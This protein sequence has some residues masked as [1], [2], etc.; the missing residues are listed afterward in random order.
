M[1]RV[2][3]KKWRAEKNT[4]NNDKERRKKE[5]E[6]ILAFCLDFNSREKIFCKE[7]RFA[8]FTSI[9]VDRLGRRF[10]LFFRLK[11]LELGFAKLMSDHVVLQCEGSYTNA[12]I[13][14]TFAGKFFKWKFA[15]NWVKLSPNLKK[16]TP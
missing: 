10:N 1:Q 2:K 6:N 11:R 5:T 7:T 3:K 15:I 8:R 4:N 14:L 12:N 16:L 13:A 9:I